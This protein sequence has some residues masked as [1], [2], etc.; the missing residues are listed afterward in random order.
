MS[1][2]RA[3]LRDRRGNVAMMWGLMGVVLAGL[4][5][6]SVDFTRAQALRTQL[7]NAADGA[8]LVAERNSNLPF[9]DREAAARAFFDAEMG[10][11]APGATFS[12]SQL[13]SGGHRATARMPMN[14]SLASL[15][16]NE[17]WNIRVASEAEA[18]ASPPIEV[19][20][21]LDNTGSMSAD[22]DDLRAAAG[23]LV[24]FLMSL[25]GDTVSVSLVPFV[26]QVNIGNGA[27]QMSW[28]DTAGANPHHGEFMEDRYLLRRTAVS[29]ACLDP[30]RFPTVVAGA[31]MAGGVVPYQ[32]RWVY[33]AGDKRC[34]AYNPSSINIFDI[35]NNLPA[36]V[37]GWRGCVE[38][39]PAPYD[40][41]D[42]APSP[43]VPATM[44]VPYFWADEGGNDTANNNWLTEATNLLAA[45][46]TTSPSSI[47]Y[48]ITARTTSLFK[49]RATATV[50]ITNAYPSMTGPHRGCPTPIIP[51]TTNRTT[52]QN[53]V[54]AMRHWSGGGTNQ[55]EGL[56]WGWR[57][58]SPGAPFTQGRPYNDPSTPVRKVLVMM[59]DG[60]NTSLNNANDAFQSDYSSYQHRRLWTDYQDDVAPAAGAPGIAPAW[61]RNGITGSTTMVDYINA[62]EVALC[63]AIKA[64]GI[65]IYTI[66][67][68]D[69]VQANEDRLR[70]CATNDE[71]FFQAANAQEL[72]EAFDAIG[73]GIG[74]LR[75]TQ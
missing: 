24:D 60:D 47:T 73:T 65:E 39:R 7:Q 14:V 59:T 61:R 57:V 58:L 68:R 10:D 38:A 3:F 46:N 54:Q 27:T 40:I 9:A 5:G 32:V 43:A 63:D 51:L 33:N 75:L 26:A 36:A 17:P 70:E 6:L 67:F 30:T 41:Q 50:S 55:A 8:A 56:A 12:V 66:Q 53:G 71:H 15:I 11:L 64:T 44:F 23:D 29:G 25:D 34:Y 45:T 74:Q 48:D 21:V 4:V 19:A 20:L 1:L 35:Y 13:D 69:T 52:V 72:Q 22:M 62:R 49:Y 16:R 2:G 42:D 18:E 28:M 31:P 37:G